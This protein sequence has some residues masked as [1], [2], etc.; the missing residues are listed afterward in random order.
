[1]MGGR[2]S[3]IISMTKSSYLNLLQREVNLT[4]EASGN[5]A[6][7]VKIGGSQG[8]G[9]NVSDEFKRELSKS[10]ERTIFVGGTPGE[11]GWQSSVHDRPSPIELRLV[12]LYELVSETLLQGEAVGA[13]R[14]RLKQAIERYLTGSAGE[15]PAKYRLNF[16]D[17]VEMILA[18]S[19]GPERFLSAH[20]RKYATTRAKKRGAAGDESTRWKLINPTNPD[21]RGAI[22]QGD[23][24][25]LVSASSGEFL[26]AKLGSDK[27]GR[28]GGSYDPGDG[29]AGVKGTDSARESAQWRLEPAGKRGRT[30]KALVS[31]DY[32]KL[33]RQWEA[34]E[35]DRENCLEGDK[36]A[37]GAEQKVFSSGR[38][39][40]A[41]TNWV[42]TK[43]AGAD[44]PEPGGT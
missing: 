29:L 32:V 2:V 16:Q 25:A 13:K 31:G 43:V 35:D 23:I 39:K 40:D 12:P 7:T 5:F 20:N 14:A 17:E 3:Q 36:K 19:E 4:A 42:I 41:G 24:I 37:T 15:D 44:G 30:D 6:N 11:Y 26:D 8:A 28:G 21:D 33:Y 38:K 18:V 27:D 22:R 9:S 10:D 34:D 1:M